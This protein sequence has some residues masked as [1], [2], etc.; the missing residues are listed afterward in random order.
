MLEKKQKL[1]HNSYSSRQQRCNSEYYV[2]ESNTCRTACLLLLHT[3]NFIRYIETVFPF[4]YR[5]LS[6]FEFIGTTRLGCVYN[7]VFLSLHLSLSLHLYLYPSH[8]SI[9]IKKN[10]MIWLTGDLLNY[11][12][13][14][15]TSF[16]FLLSLNWFT[17]QY[18]LIWNKQNKTK[19]DNT[20]QKIH[21]TH[22][23]I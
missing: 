9:L 1:D 10:Y 20:I 18:Q 8:S 13:K 15:N 5:L 17:S 4:Q 14:E 7:L 19:Q 22:T 6:S 3:T 12:V 16:N 11:W 23:H 21:T 2:C